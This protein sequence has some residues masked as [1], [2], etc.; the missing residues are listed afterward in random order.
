MRMVRRGLYWIAAV[1]VVLGTFWWGYVRKPAEA[2]AEERPV[3][4]EVEPVG[5]A[6]I[7][8]TL[9]MTGVIMANKRVELASKLAGRK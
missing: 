2:P 8:Q 1:A 7:E 9:E 5:M 3:P 6:P 4:V